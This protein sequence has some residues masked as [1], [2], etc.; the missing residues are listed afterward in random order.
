M[1][2]PNLWTINWFYINPVQ[3]PVVGNISCAHSCSVVNRQH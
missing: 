2:I 1:C 3:G